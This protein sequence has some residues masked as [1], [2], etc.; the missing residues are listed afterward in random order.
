M[1][2]DLTRSAIIM[3]EI[4]PE[5]ATTPAIR[6]M[7]AAL[8]LDECSL[9]NLPVLADVA[10]RAGDQDLAEHCIRRL[11]A[12]HDHKAQDRKAGRQRTKQSR[13]RVE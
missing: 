12:L 11:Y 8:D 3:P 2:Q 4:F 6:T 13:G 7:P 9:D 1:L 10:Y 5:M